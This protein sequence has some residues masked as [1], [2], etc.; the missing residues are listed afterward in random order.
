MKGA[1]HICSICYQEFTRK[2]N[3][4][5]HNDNLHASQAHII[6]LTKFRYGVK[7]HNPR[8]KKLGFL[9]STNGQRQRREEL[10]SDT[11]ESIGKEFEG[12]EHELDMLSP[13]DRAICLSQ[14]IVH[15]LSYEDPKEPMR[16]FL[17]GLRK[18]RF[19][20]KIIRYVAAGLELTPHH[21]KQMLMSLLD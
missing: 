4:E 11:L 13:Q 10:L 9:A 2:Y 6:P 7:G 20:E 18:H 8:N 1:Q 12:C 5:R 21:A 3:G 15:S 14:I 19:N 16:K 17:K